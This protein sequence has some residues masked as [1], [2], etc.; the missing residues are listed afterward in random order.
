MKFLKIPIIIFTLFYSAI[1]S[2]QV[3]DSTFYGWTVYEYDDEQGEKQCYIVTHPE[4]SN[5]DHNQRQKPYLMITRYQDSR[6]EEVSIYGGFE[7][8][9]N[10]EI[11]ALIDDQEFRLPTKDDMAW[12]L[13][14]SQD[15]IIIQ[16]LLNSAVLKVRSDSSI[17]TFAIDEYNLKG[18]T[19]AYARMRQICN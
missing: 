17:T 13:D 15:V 12:A 4:I 8:K 1:A 14:L 3:I 7:Y 11:I 16:K 9:L 6:S 18:I 5:S 19:R 10:S 2:A